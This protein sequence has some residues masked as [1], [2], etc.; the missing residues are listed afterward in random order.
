MLKNP[1]AGGVIGDFALDPFGQRPTAMRRLKLTQRLA[2][3]LAVSLLACGCSRAPA[4]PEEEP[5]PATVE[6]A[7]AREL[8]V[9]EWTE[10]LGTTQPLLDH[11]ARISAPIEGRVAALLPGAGGKAAVEGQEV[12]KGDVIVQL[13]TAV[14][15]ANRDKL[16]A[17][18]AETREM[19]IQAALAV[20]QA[21]LEVRRLE[22]LSQ[23]AS[24][25]G[26]GVLVSPIDLE[27][28]RIALEDAKS[29]EA[30]AD[31]K[32]ESGES[33]LKALDEQLKLYSLTSPID[34]RLGR[35]QVVRGQCLAAGTTVADVVNLD[36]AID[37]LA[38]VPPH[39]ARRLKLK[40]QPAHIVP[41]DAKA[42]GPDPE[43]RI[44]YIAAQ[45]EPDTGNFAIK[46][47]FP[48]RA[49]KLRGNS[50]VR[51]RVL[52]QPGKACLTLPEDAIMEDQDPPGVVIID[53]LKTVKDKE[54]QK[55]M[56]V[57]KA[58]KLQA[59][60]GVRDRRLHVVELLKLQDPEKKSDVPIE[61]A[62]F[63]VKSGQGLQTDDPVKIEA[64]EE[65]EGK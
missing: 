2:G 10:L 3:M 6:A 23:S 22:R 21:D 37:V 54:T 13:D 48:N 16:A 61:D 57:G 50:V 20:R 34:G 9:E 55:D 24:A 59:I 45:A 41:A 26:Q 47:R 44:E 42:S 28:A 7:A 58:R 14:I 12:H 46:L 36:D 29:R 53:G 11:V 27:K 5:A 30:G 35:V 18:Q 25:N 39:V 52:T 49:L 38:F 43:G 60:I 8:F 56:Q 65:E 51:V 19:K 1:R 17:G 31:R 33:E 40:E 62:V 63:V 15:Q 64:E 4:P 32:L